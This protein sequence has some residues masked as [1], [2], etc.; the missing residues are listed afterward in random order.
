MKSIIKKVLR[1]EHAP[2]ETEPL[3]LKLPK[4]YIDIFGFE[5]Y[6]Q[7]DVVYIEE[8]HFD[9]QNV[10]FSFFTKDEWGEEINYDETNHIPARFN[11]YKKI[12][13]KKLPKD[14]I[15]YI[16]RRLNPEYVKYLKL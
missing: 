3:Y 4:K 10:L 16:L 15:F 12:P 2:T 7:N 1:E 11:G 9:T 6:D 13:I 8:I 14:V 5:L